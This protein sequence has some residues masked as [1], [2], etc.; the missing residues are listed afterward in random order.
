MGTAHKQP[1]Y[2]NAVLY[3]IYPLS[4]ADSNGDGFG[5]LRGIL[6]HLDYLQDGTAGSLGVQAIWLSPIYVSPMADWGYDVADY[7]AIDPRFGTMDDFDQLLA[8]VHRRGMRLLMDYVPNHT[9]IEHAWFRAARSSRRHP[10]RNWYIWSDPAPDGG[11]PNNW[12]SYFGGPAWTLDEST[13]QYYLHTF[14][15]EQPDLNWRNPQVR[16]EMLDVLRFWLN[17]GVDGFRTDAVYNLLKDPE[18][19]DDPPNPSYRPGLSDPAERFLRVHSAGQAELPQLIGSFCDILSEK[20]GSFLLSEAYLNIPDLHK[21]YEACKRHPVHAPFNFNLMS[22]SWGASYYRSFIDEYEAS[23]GPHDWP[24]YVLG[25]HDRHRLVTR[26][27][28]ARAKLLAILQLTLRGLPVIYY[29]EELGLSD[30]N[31][32]TKLLRDPWEKRV[33]GMGLGRD[34]ARTPLPWTGSGE[35]FTTNEPWLPLGRNV[36]NHNVKL[37]DRDPGSFLSL[38]RHLIHLRTV[39]PA[40]ADGAYRS[41]VSDNPYVYAYLRETPLQR[42]VVVLNFDAHAAKVTLSEWLGGWVAGTH[43]VMGDGEVLGGSTIEL[44]GY[45]GRVYEVMKQR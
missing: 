21:L 5:D 8:E 41:L 27:G 45:E 2:Q 37:E 44:K 11:P 22:L 35:G 14:L 24:N 17:K 43:E 30:V 42:V 3:H 12:L 10:K 20:P 34:G 38:Y 23:L 26:I 31:I 32:P 33:P 4:F 9:S 39:M 29:G 13:G 15:P 28:E 40:L 19:R 25:N 6:Q 16:R 18:W 36:V 7:R 1:W